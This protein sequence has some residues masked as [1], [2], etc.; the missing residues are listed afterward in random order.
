MVAGFEVTA[1]QAARGMVASY[2]KHH[3]RPLVE[4][5]ADFEQ[6]LRSSGST[7]KQV[8]QVVGR[9]R[10]V[11]DGCGFTFIGDVSASAVMNFLAALRD[12]A[13][14]PKLPP[15]TPKK[16]PGYARAELA[17]ALGVPTST[18][19][20]IVRRHGLEVEGVSKARRFSPAV[21]ETIRDWIRRGRGSATTAGY[22]KAAKQ[23][24]RWLVRD[25]RTPTNPLE[26]LDAGD[27]SDIRHDRRA[28]T[29]CEMQTLIRAAAGSDRTFRGLTG[30]ERSILIAV[31]CA[32]GFRAGELASLTPR[33][34]RARRRVRLRHTEGFRGEEWQ[35][36]PATAP[37]RHDRRPPDL[38]GR[39]GRRGS[40]V[41][42]D[43]ARTCGR[44][45][46]DRL[47]GGRHPLR[48]RR[49]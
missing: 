40:G 18:I 15:P 22:L 10:K 47:G 46:A 13:A 41:A 24:V 19:A 45:A 44:H 27:T 20:A 38:L 5:L 49:T 21:A 48:R 35:G 43:L 2:E 11:I 4:H 9:A 28:L 7:A 14:P 8:G 29:E 37:E 12:D 39:P 3:E 36:G 1:R 16:R 25:R 26:H 34:V 33:I 30:P 17:T 23:F 31:A 42:R 32:S 6:S